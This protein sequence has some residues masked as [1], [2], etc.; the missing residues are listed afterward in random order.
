MAAFFA[1]AIAPSLACVARQRHLPCMAQRRWWFDVDASVKKHDKPAVTASKYQFVKS[2]IPVV[3]LETIKGVGVKGQI[4]HVRRGYARHRLVPK[5]LAA[6]G[7]WENIDAYAD[8]Q[9][10]EDPTLKARVA[11]EQG[12]LPFDWVDDVRLRFLRPAREDHSSLLVEPVSVWDILEDLSTNHELDLLPGNLDLP[13]DGITEVGVHEVPVRI[14]FRNP[15]SAAGRYNIVVNVL[16]KQ[17]QDA[18]QQR[19]EM[20]K[21]MEQGKSYRLVQRGGVVE[22]DIGDAEDDDELDEGT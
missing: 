6:F 9:L 2:H 15:E 8:P 13:D 17:S 3:L 7:T 1:R 18:E 16:S 11:T 22:D 4:V 21:A 12:L 10:I 20:K 19:E 5:G 14:A